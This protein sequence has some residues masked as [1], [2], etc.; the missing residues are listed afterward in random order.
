MRMSVINTN[1]RFFRTVKYVSF[2]G[3]NCQRIYVYDR[4]PLQSIKCN[5]QQ[6]IEKHKINT[7]RI[8]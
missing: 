4:I 1:R 3:Q 8:N 2:L 6:N 5:Q 7:A